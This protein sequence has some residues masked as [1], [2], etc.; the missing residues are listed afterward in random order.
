MRTGLKLVVALMVLAGAAYGGLRLRTHLATKGT[1][2]RNAAA[3]AAAKVA[4][5]KLARCLLGEQA[6]GTPSDRM[7]QI[8]LALIA[9]APTDNPWPTRCRPAVIATIEALE[10]LEQSQAIAS[11]QPLRRLLALERDAS[12]GDEPSHTYLTTVG[13]EAPP[14][15]QMMKLAAGTGL[16]GVGAAS[17]LPDPP[18]AAVPVALPERALGAATGYFQRAD[19]TPSGQVRFTYGDGDAKALACRLAVDG[20]ALACSAKDQTWTNLARPLSAETPDGELWVWDTEPSAAVVRPRDGDRASG[21]FGS[22]AFVREDGSITGM[23]VPEGSEGIMFARYAAEAGTVQT[24]KVTPPEGATWLGQR[25]DVAAWLGEADPEGDA[26]N[27]P[28]LVQAISPTGEM[29][30][31]EDVGPVPATASRL[32]ACRRGDWLAIAALSPLPKFGDPKDAKTSISVAFRGAKE[33]H[34]P[35]TREVALE[36]K[37][38]SLDD[39]WRLRQSCREGAMSITWLREDGALG[40]V[41]CTPKGCTEAT[42]KPIETEATIDHMDFADLDGKIL[43]ATT[44][45]TTSPLTI[46]VR[47]VL[48]R[49]APIAELAAAPDQVVIGDELHGGVAKI[50]EHLGVVS[51]GNNA[52]LLVSG[53]EQLYAFRVDAEGK[54]AGLSPETL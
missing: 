50:Q 27:R 10:R 21:P 4:W 22:D 25:A 28:L 23:T 18:A 42:S 47:A 30:D 24:R 34:A 40:Q 17:D 35:V 51:A 5:P 13:S 54:V 16:G 29:G 2:E 8:E 38:N 11:Y 33:W 20:A 53:N 3:V 46:S 36:R 37:R 43:W 7:R 15:D 14:I 6:K 9:S 48:F 44:R 31:P 39:K 19:A 52:L 41:R 12:A 26:A 49:L 1:E 32:L 45:H